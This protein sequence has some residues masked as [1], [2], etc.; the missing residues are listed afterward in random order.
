MGKIKEI[1]I[2]KAF[3][4]GLPNYGSVWASCSVTLEGEIEKKDIDEA[5][6]FVHREAQ[7]ECDVD[8]S[9]L[10]K[11]AKLEKEKGEK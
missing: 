6:E 11:K 2:A 10:R 4:R 9:W 7:K 8:P 5:Q 3:K 1:V